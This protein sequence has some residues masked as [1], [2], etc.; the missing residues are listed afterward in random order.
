ML[1]AYRFMTGSAIVEKLIV[2]RSF[3]QFYF[4][5]LQSR[6]ALLLPNYHCSFNPFCDFSI[7]VG[8]KNYVSNSSIV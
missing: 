1:V 2:A 7:M 6:D 3:L 8:L 5:M 4:L